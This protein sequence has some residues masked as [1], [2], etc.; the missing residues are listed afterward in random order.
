M[1]NADVRTYFIY[2]HQRDALL[3]AQGERERIAHTAAV[4]NTTAARESST[5]TE[6]GGALFRETF[7]YGTAGV[8][9]PHW[10]PPKPKQARA[11]RRSAHHKQRFSLVGRRT[12]NGAASRPAGVPRCG[13]CCPPGSTLSRH[14]RLLLSSRRCCTSA[15][16]ASCRVAK[17]RRPS[18]AYVTG[19]FVRRAALPSDEHQL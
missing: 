19:R 7:Q 8:S 15:L 14:Y 4:P 2:A 16:G 9:R 10:I 11:R 12:R 17:Y 18:G 13:C 6:Q 5:T 3:Y 1:N